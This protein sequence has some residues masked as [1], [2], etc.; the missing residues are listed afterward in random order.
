[1]VKREIGKERKGEEEDVFL[2]ILTGTNTKD[3]SE[4]NNCTSFS[5]SDS[6]KPCF[7]FVL[8]VFSILKI[9]HVKSSCAIDV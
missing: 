4:L 1:M 2:S 8:D 9:Y 6:E 5:Y 7:C 3:K